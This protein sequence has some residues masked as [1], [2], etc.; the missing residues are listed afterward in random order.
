MRSRFSSRAAQVAESIAV[1]TGK[2]RR[3]ISQLQLGVM[4]LADRYVDAVSRASTRIQSEGIDSRVRQRF[5]DFQINQA[6]AA[7]QIAAGPDPNINA[8]DMVVLASLTRKSLTRNLPDVIGSKAEP[9][10]EAFAGLEKDAWS[11]VDFLPPEQHTDLRRRLAASSSDATSLE[12]VAFNR[13]AGLANAND[14][15][16]NE[17]SAHDSIL[18][19]LDILTL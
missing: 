5:V 16:V 14:L 10:I 12:S 7:V 17:Q 6:T 4:R 1:R 19:L 13:L 8:V 18:A 2:K 3:F 11:L 15:P 9:I